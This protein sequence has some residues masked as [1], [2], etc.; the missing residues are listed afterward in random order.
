MLCC[1]VKLADEVCVS[2]TKRVGEN[3]TVLQLK[4]FAEVLIT[5]VT[6]KKFKSLFRNKED[7]N[8]FNN[9]V[10]SSPLQHGRC[11]CIKRTSQNP[12]HA[13]K[14]TENVWARVSEENLS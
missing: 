13:I 2:H 7:G 12:L 6:L 9:S 14:R 11:T 10:I 3:K 1:I 4:Q 5:G 8:G